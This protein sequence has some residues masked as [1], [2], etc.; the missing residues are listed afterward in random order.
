MDCESGKF[1]SNDG[2][3]SCSPCEPGTVPNGATGCIECTAGSFAAF[4]ATD[5][6]SCNGGG[7]YS[8]SAGAAACSTAPVGTK[9]NLSRDGVVQCDPGSASS[10]VQDNC[11][12]CDG[13]GQYADERG[14]AACKSAPAGTKPTSN[15]QDFENCAAGTYSIGGADFCTECEAGTFAL[16]EGATGCTV[17][18]TCPSGHYVSVASNPST[19]TTCGICGTGMV[20]PGGDYRIDCTWCNGEGE[21][22]DV[23]GGNACKTVPAGFKPN[24]TH[25]GLEA[26]P[27]GTYST[28]GTNECTSCDFGKFSTAEGSLGC[29]AASICQAGTNIAVVSTSTSDS[30]CNDCPSGTSSSAT[31]VQHYTACG[32][33]TSSPECSEK[34]SILANDHDEV[35]LRCCS[36]ISKPGWVRRPNQNDPGSWCSIW[37][38]S[39]AW[40]ACQYSLNYAGSVDFC[41]SEEARLCTKAEVEM[42]CAEG[43]GCPGM[44]GLLIWTS[45]AETVNSGQFTCTPCTG[46]GEYSDVSKMS[47]CKTAPAGKKPNSDRTGVELCAPGRYSVGGADECSE[48][49]VGKTSQE[50]DVGCSSCV[51]CGTGK[52]KISDCTP[53]VETQCGDCPKN[54]HSLSGATSISGC[55]TCDEGGYSNPGSG[56]CEQCLTGKYYDEPSNECK[57]CPQNTFS[58]S[59]ATDVNG[60]EECPAGGHSQPGD[61]YCE[62]CLTGKYY[63]EPSNECKLCPKNTFSI[64]GATDINGCNNCSAGEYSLEGSGYCEVCSQYMKYNETEKKCVC[65]ATFVEIGDGTCMCS[66]GKTLVDGKCVECEDGRYKDQ[67]GTESCTICDTAVIKGAFDTVPG[68]EKTSPASCACGLGKFS[69]PL[70]A[71]NP[72]STLGAVCKDCSDIDLPEGVNCSKIGLTLAT[73]PVKD[74]YWRSSKDNHNI[75]ECENTESCIRASPDDNCTAGHTGPICS[76]CTEGF[77]KNAFGVCAPCKSAG[78]SIG[79]YALSGILGIVITSFALRRMFGRERLSVASVTEAINNATNDKKHWSNRLKTKAK[80]LTS[81][82]QIVSKL[83]S[84]LAVQYPDVYQGF[85]MALNSV[86]NFDAIGLISVGCFLPRSMYSFYSSFLATTLTPIGLSLLLYFVTVRQK[87][88]LD[89]V[90]SNELMS[91][92]FG[93]FFG[94][95]YLIFASASTMAFTTFLCT[96]YGDDETRY[97]IADRS[98]D[99]DSNVHEKYKVLSYFMILVYPVGITA[100]YTCELWKHRLAIQNTETRED[101]PEV[102]HIVFLWCDYRPDFWWYEIYE[103]FRRLSFTGMLVFFEPGS[104]PQL[105]F[106]IILALLSSLMYVYNQPFERTEENTL[107]QISTVGIFFTLLSGILITLRDHLNEKVSEKLGA[108]LIFVNTLVFATVGV[109]IVFKPVFHVIKKFNQKHI[110]DAPLKGMGVEVAYSVD[111]FVDYFKRLIDSDEE[112]AG[113]V[114]LRVKDWTGKKKKVKKWLEET[115]AKAEWRCAEGD[116]P[117]DKARVKYIVDADI[118]TLLKEIHSVRSHHNLSPGPSSTS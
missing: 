77:N 58:T 89:P 112:E 35:A 88:R 64:T 67:P 98:I 11:A 73:L 114:E 113:W 53:A 8:S 56:Y 37:S 36:D 66:A 14:L 75:V 45:A 76:V 21:Y 23:T 40:G 16:A 13:T 102:Q 19:D 90:A 48:C 47:A 79:F 57:L 70:D 6:S 31:R 86:F 1:N 109:S 9:P 18:S 24:Y 96:T 60:C 87:R 95:T 33:G 43:T 97:L 55:K 83:P 81:F 111:A 5:C 10:G 118:E 85:A 4:G 32:G 39:D 62:Q 100:L 94:L 74:G 69:E 80:I 27:P 3:S 54:T 107:A 84:T 78:A 116:G 42:G 92:R 63:N 68:A 105:C 61:G 34:G 103:C 44:N 104:A 51:V 72:E 28:G 2:A 82:Y 59:G 7:Q 50:G 30:T 108:L 115:G 65:F 101:D 12:P 41:A 38:K 22:S 17:A 49:E 110:H 25:K 93:L 106:S 46:D 71:D 15:R 20:S 91:A 99:C 29:T 26:C 52:Y 117:I